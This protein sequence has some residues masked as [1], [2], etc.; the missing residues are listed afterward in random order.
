MIASFLSKR[1]VKINYLLLKFFIFQYV[2][3]YRM[4]TIEEK[5]KPGYL[6]YAVIVSSVFALVFAIIAAIFIVI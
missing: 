3:Q 1:R 6:F 5:G 4:I 2:S